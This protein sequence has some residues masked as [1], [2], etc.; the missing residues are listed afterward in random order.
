MSKNE[1]T[2]STQMRSANTETENS[3][4]NDPDPREKLK[5]KNPDIDPKRTPY[6][7][8]F[9]IQDRYELLEKHYREKIDKHNKNNNSAARRY[10]S[11]DEFLESF[12]GKKVKAY[13]K[14]SKNERWATASQISYFGGKDSLE[15]IFEE[16]GNAGMPFDELVE[17]YSEGYQEYIEKHNEKFPTL[18]IYKSNLHFDETTP[19]SHDSIVVMGHT[20]TGRPSDSIDNA[21]G[22]MYGYKP[23]FKG[24]SENMSKYRED[25]DKILF[26]SVSS[27][28]EDLGEQYGVPIDFEFIRT[29]QEG[30]ESYEDYK[31]NKDFAKRESNII[32]NNKRQNRNKN[33]LDKKESSLK[34]KESALQEKEESLNEENNELENKEQTLNNRE[35]MLDERVDEIQEWYDSINEKLNKKE[36]LLNRREGAIKRQED[37]TVSTVVAVLEGRT[38]NLSKFV[39]NVRKGGMDVLEK[40]NPEQLGSAITSTL[41]SANS[42]NLKIKNP[43]D[44]HK[45]VVQQEH[46][47]EGP[48]L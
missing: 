26:E 4:H 10:D 48:S 14:Q 34:D 44:V 43:L 22:E 38:D 1:V 16:L 12:E 29:G 45:N 41:V 27:R 5:H 17:A 42:G 35:N 24:K 28:L 21:L 7:K 37:V 40:V 25:N 30:S 2:A 8:M 33:W 13:G 23:N 6:N 9:E 3:F 15:D 36:E 47:D 31:K 19:H 46:V 11:M 39:D 18:P 32:K 20:K